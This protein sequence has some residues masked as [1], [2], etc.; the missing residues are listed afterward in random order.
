MK[1]ALT[2]TQELWNQF[3]FSA[4][5][6]LRQAF[7]CVKFQVRCVKGAN[8]LGLRLRIWSHVEISLHTCK[9][10]HMRTFLLH[11]WNGKKK[12]WAWIRLDLRWAGTLYIHFYLKWRRLSQGHAPLTDVLMTTLLVRKDSDAANPFSEGHLWLTK[13]GRPCHPASM[14]NEQTQGF[15]LRFIIVTLNEFQLLLVV[16]L[17]ILSSHQPVNHLCSQTNPYPPT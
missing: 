5:T 4:G 16:V 6:K 11:R 3:T 12:K 14:A 15:S 1:S 8:R 10:T 9:G 7:S 13:P 17:R 2:R